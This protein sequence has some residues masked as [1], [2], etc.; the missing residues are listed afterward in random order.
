MGWILYK[1]SLAL[2]LS[3][4]ALAATFAG[5]SQASIAARAPDVAVRDARTLPLAQLGEHYTQTYGAFTLDA[6][7]AGQT[8]EERTE[9]VLEQRQALGRTPMQWV[10]AAKALAQPGATPAL[11]LAHRP[12]DLTAEVLG[13]YALTGVTP[14]LADRAAIAASA[15]SLPPSLR[16]PFARL[17]ATTRFAYAA[18]AVLADTIGPRFAAFDPRTPILTP[19]EREATSARQAAI[20][21]GVDR[22]RAE[23]GAVLADLTQRPSTAVNAPLFS[24]PEGLVIL[25]GTGAD[26]YTRG[27]AIADPVLLVDP[28]GADVYQNSAGGA[29][30]VTPEAFGERW[31]DCNGLVVSVVADL[32]LDAVGDRYLYDG[33]PAAVQGAGGPG[34]IGILLD[35]A[36]ADTYD[37]KM[38]RGAVRVFEPI[39]YYFDGGAQGFGYAG[40]GAL[41]DNV[42]YDHYRFEVDTTHGESIWG[43]AQGFGAAGGTGVIVDA[44]GSDWYEGYGYGLT[45]DRGFEGIY[46]QGVGF[47]GG[48]GIATDL[49]S[50]KD[51]WIS[52]LK[53]V[54][55]DYYAVGFG[56][57]GG[58]GILYE[59]GGDDVYSA[60][61]TGTDPWIVPLLNCAYGTASYAGVGIVIEVAGNDDFY[62]ETNS[63]Y[64]SFVM[65]WGWGGPGQAYGV[66]ADFGGDDVYELA[67]TGSP[68]R[69]EGWGYTRASADLRTT[70]FGNENVFGSFLDVGGNDTYIGNAPAVGNNKVWAL[71][72]DVAA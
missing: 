60:I 43:L 41:I 24:D 31:L 8:A 42:G 18:Q 67:G 19:D 47:Y 17:V 49:G 38:T 32:G 1:R 56:A 25:G 44:E 13:L 53:A 7:P 21:A 61:E 16:D 5:S 65:D 6:P 36:G 14:T 68:I 54:T 15:A 37:A 4:A 35:V 50:E 62:G 69:K 58:V 20:L 45:G 46:V 39:L 2:G 27:G 22:F 51:W 40:A 34:G 52:D 3:V 9:W 48:V 23:A 72:A 59:D 64:A 26:T 33:P 11:A 10:D 70:L 30:P 55:V 12:P 63:P 57:F 29:C 66:Y 28:S 71:G